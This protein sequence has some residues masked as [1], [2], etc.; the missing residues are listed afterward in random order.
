MQQF[1]G[2]VDFVAAIAAGTRRERDA[3]GVA[4]AF[5][6]QNAH[7]SGGP[8][9]TFCAHARFGEA[10]VQRLIGFRGEVAI[11]GDQIVR[12]RN[13]AGNDDLVLAQATFE[14]ELGGFQGGEDHAL[15]DDFF[16]GFAEVLVGVFLHLAH[17]QFLIERAAVDADAHGL[18][19]VARDFADGGELLVAALAGA[20]V[21]GIDAVFI[22]RAGAIGIFGE[23][24]VAVVME[25]AD[26]RDVAAG[27]E[28]ALFDFGDGG[29][30]FGNIYGDADEFRAGLGEFE[31][32]LGGGGDV[33][34]VR[35]G[36]GLDDDGR[37][38]ADLDFAD[39]Y[40]Y[41]FV[42]LLCHVLTIVANWLRWLLGVVGGVV[43]E[44][45]GTTDERR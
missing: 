23:Q 44:F 30:G 36:H 31:A 5:V 22:E 35:V 10:E 6:E 26:E 33:D 25:I 39:F 13:F 40:A 29:G 8:D 42:A 9:E 32:L 16:G 12:P 1:A 3:D 19:V 45:K 34:G 17:D 27:I 24:D 37:A 18:V 11:D 38:A 28:Q 4:D 2:G 7:G 41:G 43:V 20:D 15:V 21:A 14:R